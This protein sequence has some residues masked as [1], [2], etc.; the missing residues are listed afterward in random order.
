MRASVAI[1]LILTACIVAV[2][3]EGAPAPLTRRE[4]PA[5]ENQW[6]VGR[7]VMHW[8][9]NEYDTVLEANGVYRAVCGDNVWVGH[10]QTAGRRLRIHERPAATSGEFIMFSINLEA[11]A[12]TPTRV[13][14]G[15]WLGTVVYFT[16]PKITD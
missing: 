15:R 7:W 14:E 9:G 1:A 16:P 12:Q 3:S 11:G 5:H 2:Y 4:R 6:M 13:D 8:N 10:W